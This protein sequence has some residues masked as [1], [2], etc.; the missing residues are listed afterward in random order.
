[1]RLYPAMMI[2]ASVASRHHPYDS[3][4]G[5]STSSRSN[6]SRRGA[7]CLLR[8]TMSCRSSFAGR[9]EPG[10]VLNT[11]ERGGSMQTFYF[12]SLIISQI[13]LFGKV[14]ATAEAEHHRPSSGSSSSPASNSQRRMRSP[15]LGR[16]PSGLFH[17][18]G[19]NAKV[20]DCV[21]YMTRDD[22]STRPRKTAR[23]TIHATHTVN[24]GTRTPK[25]VT[26]TK[27]SL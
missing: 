10:D 17:R 14:A 27:V 2:L 21:T 22:T 7:R 3:D 1:M 26:N 6:S 18:S 13:R 19:S 9:R 4:A 20:D 12:Q 16:L 24:S 25:T 15:G 23:R 11:A 5:G 8:N